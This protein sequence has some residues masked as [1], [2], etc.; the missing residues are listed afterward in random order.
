MGGRHAGHAHVSHC[1]PSEHAS[2]FESVRRR[3]DTSN[4]SSCTAL[5]RS[6]PFCKLA[7]KMPARPAPRVHYMDMHTTVVL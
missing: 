4:C 7:R 5:L 2:D 6:A 1:L 3:G